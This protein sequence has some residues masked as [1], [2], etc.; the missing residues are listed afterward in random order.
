M[1]KLSTLSRP[2]IG[3]EQQTGSEVDQ[4]LMQDMD[5]VFSGEESTVIAAFQVWHRHMQ[6]GCMHACMGGHCCMQS[7]A[8]MHLCA[9][10]DNTGSVYVFE[11]PDHN[12]SMI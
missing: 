5:S 9:L 2:S 4:A 10:T 8:T 6:R 12:A 11:F 7:H 1:N 3:L